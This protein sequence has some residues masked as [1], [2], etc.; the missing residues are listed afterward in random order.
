MNLVCVRRVR[1]RW[2]RR[3]C[4][5]RGS[6]TPSPR[7]RRTWAPGLPSGRSDTSQPTSRGNCL[8]ST[9]RRTARGSIPTSTTLSTR[10]KH[11]KW[12][13]KINTE[14]HLY[15]LQL[16]CICIKC[17]HDSLDFLSPPARPH[18]LHVRPPAELHSASPVGPV[19]ASEDTE[20]HCLSLMLYSFSGQSR[21]GPWS[22]PLHSGKYLLCSSCILSL[23]ADGV[24]SCITFTATIQESLKLNGEFWVFWFA[25]S[26]F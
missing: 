12:K 18:V 15:C 14:I 2:R 17:L 21:H 10:R 11:S 8:R 7:G 26:E 3:W 1:R 25:M 9:W 6:L 4:W 16:V 24:S 23:T 22:L 13:L 20:I 5:P 19:L